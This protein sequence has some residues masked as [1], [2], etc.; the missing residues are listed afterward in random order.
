MSEKQKQA[1]TSLREE[2]K[3]LEN[4]QYQARLLW[5]S[6]SRPHNNYHEARR[7]FTQWEDR[8]RC[9]DDVREAFH[10]A[11]QRWIACNYLEKVENIVDTPQNFLT[12]FVV[13]KE[14]QPLEK[15]RLVVNGSRKFKGESLNDFLEPGPNV[16]N[17][18]GEL[19]LRLRRHRYLVCCDLAQMF[20]NIRVDPQD[21]QYLRMFYRENPQDELQVYQFAVHAFGLASS[22]CVAISCV[23]LHARKYADKWPIAEAAIR[24]NSMVD[25]IWLT[26]DSQADL[27]L[28]INEIQEV[29]KSMNIEVHKWG[30]NCPSLLAD[31]PDDKR[32]KVITLKDPD[33]EV[34]RALGV[35]WDTEH[36]VFLFPQ[37]P[38]ELVPWT[39][40]KMTSSSARLFDPLG[41]VSPAT[42]PAKLLIQ[43]AWRYQDAWDELLPEELGRK[44]SLYCHNQ[45]LLHRVEIPR[46]LGGRNGQ[47]R[48][49][50]FTDSSSMAQAAAAYWLSSSGE[51]LESNLVASKVKVT[52]LRQHEHIG[53]LEL[54]AAVMGVKLAEK[55]ARTYGL[56]LNNVQYFTDSMAVLYWLSTTMA[57]TPYA[58]HRVAQIL[59]R[60]SFGQWKYVH[61]SKNP[62]D[63]PTRGM[64]AKDLANCTLWW[65]GPEFLREPEQNW[66]EQPFIRADEQAVAETRTVEEISQQIVL[67]LTGSSQG[68]RLSLILKLKSLLGNVRKAIKALY[69]LSSLFYQKYKNENF[70]LSLLDWEVVWIRY[71]Q[72]EK[73]AKLYQELENM[74]RPSELLEL[75]PRLDSRGVIR[76]NSGISRSTF[77]N[78][79]TAFP[80]LLKGDMEY[81]KEYLLYAHQT[82]LAH[83]GGVST[84]ANK[85]RKRFHVIGG[86]RLASEVVQNCFR[87]AKKSWKPIQMPS[88]DF[89]SNR[90]GDEFTPRAFMEIGIDHMGPF[91]LRQG[92]STVEGYVL[93][94]ACCATRAINLE[95]S[96]STGSEHVIAALQ[97]HVGVYGP[98]SHI[99]SDGGTG[100]VKARRVIQ[101][102]A[103][104]LSRDGWDNL[105]AP[106]WGVNVPYSPTWSSHVE[107]M[108]KLTKN[109]LQKLHTGPIIT[110]LTTD[111]FYTQLKRCQGYI[112]MRPLV[113]SLGDR[114]P[115]TP[116][117]FIGTG[118]AWLTSFVYAPEDKGNV[119]FR[120]RQLEKIRKELWET[121]REDY[122]GWLRRQSPGLRGPLPEVND[123][124]LVKD[125]PAWKGN[126]WPVARVI[127]VK[128]GG[129]TPRVYELEIVPTEELRKKPQPINKQ[130]KLKLE[131][132]VILRNYRQ[133]GLLPKITQNQ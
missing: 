121:F 34:I 47:G 10:L 22:P 73:F 80:I 41:L 9:D 27:S 44:M 114:P 75:D 15:G 78:W 26:S 63:I 67:P 85:V 83:L 42:L 46:H 25:D 86:R 84:L 117:D 109:A 71:E 96:L 16:I 108:V 49:V 98:P 87:C 24:E 56:D 5:K 102:N 127:K 64:R 111:E 76:V 70:R 123:L 107:S 3:Q 36:D 97:R 116:A 33:R 93:V 128:G 103:S 18:I 23:K 60:S 52:G 7:A 4:G 72:K 122:V 21:R 100:F 124:V 8:L 28:G 45:K 17:D 104:L 1:E 90:F 68:S 43:H 110:K 29:M 40:R 20:L 57:L 58:G 129:T 19:L 120:H 61:T 91:Q 77:H 53:R 2:L 54:V 113:D 13:L 95:M 118:C 31:I 89:H 126:G 38:P 94:I 11:M 12:G 39:L 132:K 133:L 55:V 106:R 59:E 131:K 6:A 81:C 50:I 14:G 37:G 65:K 66:P 92:R 51:V 79:E 130:Y 88:P 125:V 119:G 48:L 101:E 115:L 74:K 30:S 62:S 112:N 82:E 32:A 105:D 69:M 99:N 35:A